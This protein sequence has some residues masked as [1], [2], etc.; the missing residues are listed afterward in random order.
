MRLHQRRHRPTRRHRPRHT[1]QQLT[2]S[3]PQPLRIA[4]LRRIVPTVSHR[5]RIIPRGGVP[6]RRTRVDDRLRRLIA[7][8]VRPQ[9]A[10]LPGDAHLRRGARWPRVDEYV[11]ERGVHGEGGGAAVDEEEHLVGEGRRGRVDEGARPH[12]DRA[13]GVVGGGGVHPA[14]GGAAAQG[15]LVYGYD[16]GVGDYGE[17]GGED[18]AEV[19]AE[20]EG[21]FDDGPWRCVSGVV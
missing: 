20:D 17:V 19:V 18:L 13:D 8:P 2:A 7:H 14:A 15:V 9:V 4:H 6:R 10:Q 21:G 12:L 11:G 1:P 16:G 5:R 3:H